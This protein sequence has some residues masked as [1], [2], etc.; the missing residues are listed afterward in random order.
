MRL[1]RTRSPIPAKLQVCLMKR[2]QSTQSR[3]SEGVRHGKTMMVSES[4]ESVFV[5]GHAYGGVHADFFESVDFALRFDSAGGDDGVFSSSAEFAEPSEIFA[6]HGAFAVDVGAE[7]GGAKRFEL[8]DDVFR[9]KSETPAPAMDGDV[10]A[11]GVE[12]DDDLFAREFFVEGA[13]EAD[14]DFTFAEGGAANDDLAG[15]PF[16]DFRGASD[17]SNAA[18]DADIEFVAHAGAEAEFAG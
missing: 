13:E 1:I 3:K 17:G 15:A 10:T 16:C 4:A 6:G 11:D 18:A 5:D 14:I 8:G 2:S 7:E 12:G 9:T